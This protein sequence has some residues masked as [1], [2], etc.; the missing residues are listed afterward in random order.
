MFCFL[1]NNSIN[2][3][4]AVFSKQSM[5]IKTLTSETT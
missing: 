3:W 1:I 5:M 2:Q 4:E